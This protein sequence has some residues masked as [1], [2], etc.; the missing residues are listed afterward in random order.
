MQNEKIKLKRGAPTKYKPEY[1]EE[2]IKYFLDHTEN[3]LPLFEEFSTKIGVCVD[4][5]KEWRDKHED[6][7]LAYQ[8][9]KEIQYTYYVEKMLKGEFNTAFGIFLG[10]NIFKMTD[11]HELEAK[12]DAGLTIEIVKFGQKDNSK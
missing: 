7:S 12:V 3:K 2:I 10:K 6:F 8:K 9:A 11:R 4:S 1:C 5:L